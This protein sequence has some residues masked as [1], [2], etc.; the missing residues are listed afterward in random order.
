MSEND[1]R[2]MA[3]RQLEEALA[4]AEAERSRN[5]LEE[6][7]EALSRAEFARKQSENG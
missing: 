4:K 6:Y 2:A 1:R 3:E 7:N 5:L